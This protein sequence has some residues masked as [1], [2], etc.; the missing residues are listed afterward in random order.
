M[1]EQGE[2]T[3]RGEDKEFSF[4]AVV[5]LVFYLSLC[6]H[7]RQGGEVPECRKLCLVMSV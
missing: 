4:L 7:R 2:M 3:W 6:E 5:S 1:C